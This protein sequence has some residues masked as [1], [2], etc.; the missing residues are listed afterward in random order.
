MEQRRRPEYNLE[1]FAD[2]AC[3]KDVVKGESALMPCINPSLLPR[4][5][6]A[7]HNPTLPL[8]PDMHRIR[9]ELLLID[10]TQP[11]CTRSSSTVTLL[12]YRPSPAT[13]S[14]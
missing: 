10:L 6:K 9:M 2:L 13:C 11:S 8:Y 1:I 12:P 14:I 5:Q 3:V 7:V 4:L